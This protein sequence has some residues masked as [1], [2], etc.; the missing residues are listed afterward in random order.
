MD[1]SIINRLDMIFSSA[2]ANP[3]YTGKIRVNFHPYFNWI[4]LYVETGVMTISYNSPPNNI[5]SATIIW[6]TGVSFDLVMPSIFKYTKEKV[7]GKEKVRIKKETVPVE[8][9]GEKKE[10]QNIEELKKIQQGESVTFSN[11]I[12][13]PDSDRIKEESYP[14]IDKISDVLKERSNISIEIIGH[15]NDTNKPEAELALSKKRAEMVRNYLIKKGIEPDRMKATGLGSRFTKKATIEE[16]NRKVE[17]KILEV[18][19]F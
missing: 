1:F 5:N 9:I 19:Q 10:E 8:I 3:L 11:I 14:E 18:K 16:A 15:T 7:N 2:Y 6:G 17:I 12:F 4:K 13:Y